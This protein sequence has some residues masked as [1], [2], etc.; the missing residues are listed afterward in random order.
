MV[1]TELFKEETEVCIP[2]L[3]LEFMEADAINGINGQKT[4]DS[5]QRG[6]LLYRQ[7]LD[8]AYA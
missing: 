4:R 8:L 3:A 5:G 2:P 1:W 7:S 6:K